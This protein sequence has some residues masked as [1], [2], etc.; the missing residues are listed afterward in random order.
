M[1]ASLLSSSVSTWDIHHHQLL[2][3]HSLENI[4]KYSFKDQLLVISWATLL[5]NII[6][7][8]ITVMVYVVQMDKLQNNSNNNNNIIIIIIIIIYLR[9][10]YLP[11]L[12]VQAFSQVS[13]GIVFMMKM[14]SQVCTIQILN[15]ADIATYV[16]SYVK[17]P[18]LKF[19]DRRVSWLQRCSD[20]TCLPFMHFIVAVGTA[21]LMLVACS[22]IASTSHLDYS[23]RFHDTQ[24]QLNL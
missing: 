20:S 2:Y 7:K 21:I 19:T 24:L 11:V 3:S 4:Y 22:T 14:S 18:S 12:K 15:L 9:I 8:Y 23:G 17:L 1:P 6:V 10:F 16:S 13:S 5:I